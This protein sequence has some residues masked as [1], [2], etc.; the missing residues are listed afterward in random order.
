M[1]L[2]RKG[3]FLIS[4]I[5]QVGGR[6]F[7]KLL[8]KHHIEEINSAQGRILFALWEKDNISISQI[9][10]KTQLEKSTLTSMLDRLEQSGFIKRM[11][12]PDDRRKIII[13]RTEKD[14]KFQ[15]QYLAV[16][17]E[18]NKVFYKGF[19][20][21]KISSFEDSLERILNNLI[22]EEKDNE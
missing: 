15:E 8:K 13:S 22:D 14:K 20:D 10:E 17:E 5:H 11:P 7:N 1:R 21:Q 6:I 19:T 4:K 12:S 3:G 2:K 18:M 9:S 16:S